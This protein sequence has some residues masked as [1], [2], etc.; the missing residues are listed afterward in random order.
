ME[1]V[2]TIQDKEPLIFTDNAAEKKKLIEREE[3]C[4]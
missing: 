2:T 1:N 4:S 3:S